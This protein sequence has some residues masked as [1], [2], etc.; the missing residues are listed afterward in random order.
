MADADPPNRSYPRFN[1]VALTVPEKAL[2]E[3][4]RAAL[5]AFYG[6]VFGWTEMPTMTVDRELLVLRCYS[7]EQFVYIHS[8]ERPM[9]TAGSEHIGLS[10]RTTA[11]LD[12]M[13]ER[14]KKYGENDGDVELTKRGC[15][16]F[17]VVKIHN[18]YVR[19][20]LPLQ[21]EVQCFEW[22]EGAGEFATA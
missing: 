15:D 16:D 13:F 18:F 2:D 10:V 4:G 19:Y 14:A 6:A 21:I 9:E 11:E 1:H 8:A 5:L 22:A 7:N 12:E 17:K 3:A 20:H